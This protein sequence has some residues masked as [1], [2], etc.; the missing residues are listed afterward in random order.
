M[1]GLA[2]VHVCACGDA[3]YNLEDWRKLG[4]PR[5]EWSSLGEGFVVEYRTCKCGSTRTVELPIADIR[6]EDAISGAIEQRKVAANIDL[7]FGRRVIR[8]ESALREILGIVCRSRLAWLGDYLS[9]QVQISE[10]T[11]KRLQETLKEKV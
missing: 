11:V 2:V 8:A 7:E 9:Y 1:S 4:H 5:H 3:F 10:D 6:V